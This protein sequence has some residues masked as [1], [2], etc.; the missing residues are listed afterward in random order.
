MIRAKRPRRYDRSYLLGL[1]RSG[2]RLFRWLMIRNQSKRCAIRESNPGLVLGKHQC[3]HYTNGALALTSKSSEGWFRS[4][5][6]WVMSPTRFRCATSLTF[7]DKNIPGGIRTL[8]L[9]LRKQ[10]PYHWATGTYSLRDSNPQTDTSESGIRAG[11]AMSLQHL[12]NTFK[13]GWPSG[14]RRWFKAPVSSGAWVRIPLR[15]PFCFC[16]GALGWVV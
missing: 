1:D 7:A 8:G 12:L 13:F 14:L 5:D 2:K 9:L 4:T 11:C 15:T 6:L 16:G 3:Y 10:T